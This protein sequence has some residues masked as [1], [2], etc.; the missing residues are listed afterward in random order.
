VGG[1]AGA[2]PLVRHAGVRRLTP[3]VT[4]QQGG[5]HEWQKELGFDDRMAQECIADLPAEELY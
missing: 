1:S 3:D 2:S 5:A 4:S